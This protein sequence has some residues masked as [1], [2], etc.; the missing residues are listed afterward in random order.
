MTKILYG[1]SENSFLECAKKWLQET[2]SVNFL[3]D[4]FFMFVLLKKAEVLFQKAEIALDE[5]AR[6][7]SAF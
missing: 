4:F 3:H 7:I 5:A 2:S 6:S 1:N